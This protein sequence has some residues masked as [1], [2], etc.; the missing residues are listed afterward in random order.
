MIVAYSNRYE[1]SECVDTLLKSYKASAWKV[2]GGHQVYDEW[3][4]DINLPTKQNNI[5]LPYILNRNRRL[6]GIVNT[7]NGI[8]NK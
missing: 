3:C 1:N 5:M 4:I 2:M 8:A 6:C 7:I